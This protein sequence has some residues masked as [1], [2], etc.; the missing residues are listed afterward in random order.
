VFHSCGNVSSIIGDLID[1]GVDVMD[2]LQSEA[3]DL[4]WVAREFGGK[5]AFAG[6][7]PEQTL[8]RLTPAGVRDEVHRM[9]DLMGGPYGNAYILAPSNSL[10]ADVPPANLEALFEACHDR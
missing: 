10:L 7:L 9:I 6:G 2:P 3:M 1:A 4:A 8:P 5:V